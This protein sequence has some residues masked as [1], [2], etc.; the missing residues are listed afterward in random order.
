MSQR[1]INYQ[2]PQVPL[3]QTRQPHRHQ[4]AFDL[5]WNIPQLSIALAQPQRLRKNEEC[6]HLSDCLTCTC[7][8]T[9]NNF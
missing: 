3:Q 1:K 9:N 2:R 4:T 8:I 7:A 5:W 6:R